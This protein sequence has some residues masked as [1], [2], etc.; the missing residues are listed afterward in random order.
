MNSQ[1]SVDVPPTNGCKAFNSSKAFMRTGIPSKKWSIPSFT[2]LPMSVCPTALAAAVINGVNG[3]A[4][5]CAAVM[6]SPGDQ[7]QNPA[8]PEKFSFAPRTSRLRSTLIPFGPSFTSSHV[9]ANRSGTGLIACIISA[10]GTIVRLV[11]KTPGPAGRDIGVGISRIAASGVGLSTFGA[12]G[13]AGSIGGDK[14][15]RLTVDAAFLLQGRG[16]EGVG[17]VF[18]RR[19]G[20][21]SGFAEKESLATSAE[22]GRARLGWLDFRNRLKK[23]IVE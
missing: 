4:L 21:S 13:S 19:W 5:L 23:G 16:K 17:S 1:R 2:A 11:R 6:A 20:D 10:G 7:N 22:A 15:A 3:V 14:L 9:A 18:L 12:M 8:W